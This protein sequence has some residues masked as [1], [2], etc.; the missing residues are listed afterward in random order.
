MTRFNIWRNL[1][2]RARGNAD[3]GQTKATYDVRPPRGAA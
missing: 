2:D 1:P 3:A